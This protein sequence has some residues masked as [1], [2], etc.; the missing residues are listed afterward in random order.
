MNPLSVIE[1][2]SS[3]HQMQVTDNGNVFFLFALGMIVAMIHVP[4][5]LSRE[6]SVLWLAELSSSLLF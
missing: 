5:L 1:Q 4:P 6:G 3:A 2:L